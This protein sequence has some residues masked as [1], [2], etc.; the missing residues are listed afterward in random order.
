MI[1][2]LASC[3]R[4][5]KLATILAPILISCEVIMEVIIPFLMADL[6]DKGI[7]KGDMSYILQR[8]GLLLLCA[9]ISLAF[10]VTAAMQAAKASC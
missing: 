8:G 6:I 3:I 4:E 7:N 2:K 1:K 9:F 5:Y 10:G